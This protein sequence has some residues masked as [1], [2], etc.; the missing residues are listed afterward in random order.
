M[1]IRPGRNSMRLGALAMSRLA[2]HT[3]IVGDYRLSFSMRDTKSLSF[4][5]FTGLQSSMRFPKFIWRKSEII[6]YSALR[7]LPVIFLCAA[8]DE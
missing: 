3:G 5:T 4:T 7:V 8:D 2:I 1:C 6:P